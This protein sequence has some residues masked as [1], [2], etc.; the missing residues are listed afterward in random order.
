MW[1]VTIIVGDYTNKEEAVQQMIDMGQFR[2]QT[3][4][5]DIVL[6]PYESDAKRFIAFGPGF[7]FRRAF[8]DEL[9]ARGFVEYVNNHAT[10][11][12][13]ATFDGQEDV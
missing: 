11:M 9:N 3:N 8:N 2:S 6:S 1:I 12:I 10:G 4:D 7:S 5:G 13:T